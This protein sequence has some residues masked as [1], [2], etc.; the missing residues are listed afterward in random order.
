MFNGNEKEM[1][2]FLKCDGF[3]S[4]MESKSAQL[5]LATSANLKHQIFLSYNISMPLWKCPVRSPQLQYVPQTDGLL[6]MSKWALLRS[7]GAPQPSLSIHTEI[8][9]DEQL[10]LNLRFGL[11]KF[12]ESG[13]LLVYSILQPQKFLTLLGEIIRRQTVVL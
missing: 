6:V 2:L 7:L 1:Q 11:F 10:L 4:S 9:I 3:I 5:L 13:L 8:V 12:S